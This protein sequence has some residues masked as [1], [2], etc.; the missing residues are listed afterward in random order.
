MNN[1]EGELGFNPLPRRSGERPIYEPTPAMRQLQAKLIAMLRDNYDYPTPNKS[2]TH[3]AMRLMGG[4]SARHVYV[5]DLKGAYQSVDLDRLAGMMNNRNGPDGR[6]VWFG[7]VGEA[8]AL[9]ALTAEAPEGGLIQG[10]PVS[11]YL[12]E[13]YMEM[14]LDRHLVRYSDELEHG[15]AINRTGT[16]PEHRRSLTAWHNLRY[17]RFAD[18]LVFSSDNVPV[19]RRKRQDINRVIRAAGFEVNLQK[20][21]NYDLSRGPIHLNGVTI[22]RRNG[23][24]RLSMPKAARARLEGLLHLA[25]SGRFDDFDDIHGLMSYFLLATPRRPLN[26]S[27]QRVVDAYC[28]LRRMLELEERDYASF[29]IYARV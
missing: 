13:L 14:M 12:F 17:S 5:V 24:I 8:R 22:R 29:P 26:Q 2:F 25:L 20:T 15:V 10:A 4:H 7:D 21:R 23:R 6:K 28:D 18:D 11:P 19:G 3:N 16:R 9:I 1:V 27:E